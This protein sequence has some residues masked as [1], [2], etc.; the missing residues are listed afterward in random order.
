MVARRIAESVVVVL[1]EEDGSRQR[2]Q[3]HLKAYGSRALLRSAVGMERAQYVTVSSSPALTSR[4]VKNRNEKA[5]TSNSQVL[6]GSQLD[7]GQRR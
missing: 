2:G 6:L 7:V 1:S 5:R 3:V 4:V